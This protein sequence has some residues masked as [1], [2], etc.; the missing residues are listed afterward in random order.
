MQDAA[1]RWGFSRDDVGLETGNRR[2]NPEARILVVVAASLGAVLTEF[3]G[4]ALGHGDIVQPQ[5][6]GEPMDEGPEP[7]PLDLPPHADLTPRFQ[8]TVQTMQ[9][10]KL[11]TMCCTETGVVSPSAT[12]APTSAVSSAPG[13]PS[14]SR[15]EKF[16]VV[17]ATIW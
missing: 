17:G 9:G 14:A 8:C 2:V 16:Q 10:S 12:G 3:F 5:L 7:D 1:E 13:C 11:R 6:R 15:G 4:A